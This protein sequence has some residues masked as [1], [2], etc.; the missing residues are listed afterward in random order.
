MM[1]RLAFAALLLIAFGAP[2]AAAQNCALTVTTLNFGTYAATLLNGTA[3]GR[4]TC[5]GAWDIP[6]NAGIGA[7]G[8]E[9][10]RYMTGPGGAELAYKLFQNSART[11]NWGNTQG[12]DLN[13]NGN[14]NITVYGQIPAGQYVAQ[15]TYTDTISSATTTF[16]VTVVIQAACTISAHN[17]AF[18]NYTGLLTESTSTLSVNCTKASTYNVGLNAGLATGATVSNRSMTG[19]AAALLKYNLFSNSGYTTNWGNT[20]GTNTLAGTGSGAAQTLTVYGQIPAGQFVRPGSYTDTITA[21][22]TY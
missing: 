13:G 1:R 22:I 16:E 8:S 10:T 4:V 20:V 2:V 14:S 19:P 7:G 17:L 3:T 9:T 11:T 18:G 5:T 6:L 15:G 12:T 21:T